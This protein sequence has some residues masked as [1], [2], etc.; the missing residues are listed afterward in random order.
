MECKHTYQ[1][2]VNNMSNEEFKSAAS[3]YTK[4]LTEQEKTTKAMIGNSNLVSVSNKLLQKIV[5]YKELQKNGDIKFRKNSSLTS[6]LTSA[7]SITISLAALYVSIRGVPGF[8][9]QFLAAG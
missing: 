4:L 3:P 6:A 1:E 2:R 7:V 9:I 8:L 5:D